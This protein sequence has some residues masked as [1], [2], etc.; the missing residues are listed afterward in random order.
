M[1]TNCVMTENMPL[2]FS[3]ANQTMVNALRV[4]NHPP[5][6]LHVDAC[7]CVQY[8]NICICKTIVLPL[9][10]MAEHIMIKVDFGLALVNGACTHK[11]SVLDQGLGLIN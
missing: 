5:I 1:N 11:I 7:V 6:P 3:I 4:N 2:I 8:T 9:T 10:S